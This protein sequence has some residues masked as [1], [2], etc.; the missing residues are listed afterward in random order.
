MHNIRLLALDMDGTVLNENKEITPRT[1]ASLAAAAGRGVELV[2]AT[3]RLAGGV[4]AAFLALP[5]VRYIIASNGATVVERATGRVLAELP[6]DLAQAL[7]LYELLRGFDCMLGVF[8]GGR[9]YAMAC[10]GG[11]ADE[12]TPPN[13]RAYIR[14]S[15]A[16]VP[17]LRPV[18]ESDPAHV[19]K[20]TVLYR[21]TA[22]RDAARAAVAAAFPDVELTMSLGCNLEFNAHG[23]NK[24]RALAELARQLGL[25]PAEVMACGDSGNDL[26]MIRFAGVGVAMGNADAAVKAAARYIAPDN[27]H[28]G[29]AAAVEKFVLPAAA[30]V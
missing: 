16:V 2:P 4:P 27:E 3:G 6:F 19:E 17:D 10:G 30:G 5:G 25:A 13:L 1:R 20:Y 11:D 15:R 14:G 28:D 18:L 8:I 29:V 22:T 7:A 9:G 26:A 12:Y 21:D 24:G 23:V